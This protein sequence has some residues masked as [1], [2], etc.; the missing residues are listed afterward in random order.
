MNLD[1][2]YTGLKVANLAAGMT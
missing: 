2:F 1:T